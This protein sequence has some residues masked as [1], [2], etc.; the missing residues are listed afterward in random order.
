MYRAARTGHL[1][2]G[3]A[4]TY[5]ADMRAARAAAAAEQDASFVSADY[6]LAAG[7]VHA[8]MS[9]TTSE[10]HAGAQSFVWDWVCSAGTAEYTALGRAYAPAAPPL[11]DTA[12]AAALAQIY[13]AHAKAR[14]PFLMHRAAVR[15]V[16]YA[17]N[18]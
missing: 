13:A 7:V 5:L 18:S 11:G 3:S 2:R 12:F 16:T 1:P 8:A 6:V 9:T 15:E 14:L 4:P 17:T 10:W